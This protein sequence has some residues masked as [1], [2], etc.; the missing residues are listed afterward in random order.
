MTRRGGRRWPDSDSI[1]VQRAARVV[2]VRVTAVSIGLVLVIVLLALVFIVDQ[3]RP[4]ELLE[5]PRPGQHKI[6]VD[7]TELIVAVLVL[8]IC[9]IALA[10]VASWTISRGAVRPLGAALRLQREFVSDASHE[11]R[12]PITVLS[13]RLQLLERSRSDFD[14][15][16]AEMIAAL[17]TDAR[18]LTE[19][20]EDLLLAAAG[21]AVAVAGA[22]RQGTSSSDVAT[23]VGEAV[24]AMRVLAGD[25]QVDIR[26]DVPSSLTIRLPAPA[27]RRALVAL[28]DNAIAHAPEGSEVTVRASTEKRMIALVVTDHGSGIRGLDPAR[29]FDRFSRSGLTASPPE[30]R[31]FGIGLALV[32]DLAVRAGGTVGVRSTSEDGT[33]M[34]LLLPP[35]S[36][37][38]PSRRRGRGR[39]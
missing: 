14:E 13:T 32:R 27:L 16:S 31:S 23:V 33:S 18:S 5:R 34:E 12:T 38:G 10:G 19:V 4:A 7:G 15:R 30:R 39:F 35:G 21:D 29:V 22:G 17:R 11:L 36:G 1:A 25:R 28:I 26:Q 9:A 20:V 24:T 8:G 37:P 2:A 6:Y 3:S